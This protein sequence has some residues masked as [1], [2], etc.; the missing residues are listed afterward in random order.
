MG[1]DSGPFPIGTYSAV[2]ISPLSIPLQP[3]PAINAPARAPPGRRRSL[4]PGLSRDIAW[5]YGYATVAAKRVAPILIY[6]TEVVFLPR[7]IDVEL[8]L[9]CI[10]LDNILAN[11]HEDSLAT[12][13]RRSLLEFQCKRSRSR[14]VVA[15][16]HLRNDERQPFTGRHLL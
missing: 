16:E 13:R 6:E 4:K 1:T 14:Y 12:P 5:T 8:V 2:R 3:P 9:V 11:E 10:Y 15:G 7:Q